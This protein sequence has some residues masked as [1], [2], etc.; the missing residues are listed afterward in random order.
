MCVSSI[1]ESQIPSTLFYDQPF[2]SKVHRMTPNDIE[3][4]LKL[5]WVLHVNTC[6][7]RKR[8]LAQGSDF[9]HY[10]GIQLCYDM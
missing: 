8:T 4:L 1:L 5:S 9:L 7:T 2:L 10:M 6:M 3:P